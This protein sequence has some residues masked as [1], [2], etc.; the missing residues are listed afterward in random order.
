MTPTTWRWTLLSLGLGYLV[1][2]VWAL[3]APVTVLLA[4]LA[5]TSRN[6]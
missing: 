1:L 3:A 5:R 2:A 4:Y 6:A